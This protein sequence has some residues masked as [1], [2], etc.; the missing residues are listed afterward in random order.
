M[1]L[2]INPGIFSYQTLSDNPDLRVLFVLLDG[3][4]DLPNPQLNGQTPLEAATTPNI[5]SLARK[6]KM[7]QVISVG[8][9]ISPQSDIAVFNMLGYNF[10]GKKYAGRGIVEIVGSDIDFRDG[11]LALRGNFATLD[12]NKIIDRRAGRDITRQ[13]ASNICSFLEQNLKFDDPDV[14]VKINPTISHR[15]IIK[16]RH[17][18]KFLSDKITNTD[19]AYGKLNGIGI[20]N[21]NVENMEVQES[22][23]E[24]DSESSKLSARIVNEFT[25]KSIVLMK[26]HPVNLARISNSKKPMN[27]I[28]LRDAGNSVPHLQPINERFGISTSCLVDMPVEIGIAKIIGMDLF[29]SQKIDDYQQKAKEVAEI[30]NSYNL[31]YVHIKGPD[32]FGHDGDA[33]GKKS[34]IESIDENFFGMFLKYVTRQHVVVISG[35][36]STPCVKKSHTDDPIPLL[37][38]GDGIKGDGSQRFTESWANKGSIGTLKGSEVIPSVLNMIRTEKPK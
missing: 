22:Q 11:D 34:N 14:S 9:G 33:F 24:E 17:N 19:P 21:T 18:K 36:H 29:R 5:D 23:P 7:G 6:G 38:S 37:V 1:T 10:E 35:D 3:I 27:V 8:K 31:V 15:V 26:E 32:E 16:F 28:L 13:E 25:R 30:L 20:A 2:Q 12:D 4:G